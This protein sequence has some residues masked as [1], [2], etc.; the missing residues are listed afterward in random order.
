MNS[1]VFHC[2]RPSLN[3]SPYSYLKAILRYLNDESVDKRKQPLNVEEWTTEATGR[4]GA[5]QQQNG[6][7]CGMFS[8][9]YADFLSDDLPL[10]FDQSEI[11]EYRRKTVAAILRGQLNYPISDS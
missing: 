1:D 7:D 2:S 5:P 6:Y 10:A 9:M 3:C 8:T 4:S 11:C